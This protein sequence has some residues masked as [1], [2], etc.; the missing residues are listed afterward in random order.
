MKISDDPRMGYLSQIS[1]DRSRVLLEPQLVFLCGGEVNVCDPN[2]VSVRNMFMRAVS[3][4]DDPTYIL[5]ESFNDWKDGYSDLSEFEND[6]AHL[7]SIVVLI[8]ESAGAIAEL[9]YFYA[10]E[11]IRGKL[12]IIVHDSY[13][14]DDSF[15]KHGFLLPMQELDEAMVLSYPIDPA[16]IEKISGD[17]VND[18]VSAI[19]DRCI[20]SPKSEQFVLENPGHQ[21]FLIFEILDNFLA[22]TLLEIE[23][24]LNTMGLGLSRKKIKSR[25]FILKKFQLISERRRSSQTFYFANYEAPSR[26]KFKGHS[27]GPRLDTSSFKIKLTQFYNEKAAVDVGSKNRI[28]VIEAISAKGSGK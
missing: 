12:I 10:H 6:I 8:L 27:K 26:I 3:S 5:A 13:Y 22:L 25:L 4:K 23:E 20:K 11:N 9:G 7:S 16:N 28:R 24:Y 2:N 17:D 19:D 1:L 18:I 21:A 15:I 14:D